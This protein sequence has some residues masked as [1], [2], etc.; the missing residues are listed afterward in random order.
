MTDV[1]T[2]CHESLPDDGSSLTCVVCNYPY[3]WGI[4]YGIMEATKN[5]KTFRKTWRCQTCV[6]VQS[7]GGQS[8]QSKKDDTEVDVLGLLAVMNKKT[9]QLFNTQGNRRWHRAFCAT[10]VGQLR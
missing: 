4:C 10:N 3:H 8:T 9:G 2:K 5:T 6:T 7:R 1:C